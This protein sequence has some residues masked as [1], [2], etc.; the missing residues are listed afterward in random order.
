[1]IFQHLFRCWNLI[2]PIYQQSFFSIFYVS[3]DI[4]RFEPV[5][6][7][8]HDGYQRRRRRHAHPQRLLPAT[9]SAYAPPPPQSGLNQ[10]IL[11]LFTELA[12]QPTGRQTS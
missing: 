4:T 3:A 10:F 12:K 7:T 9:P 5:E 11:I 1:M 2:E 8:H 6:R